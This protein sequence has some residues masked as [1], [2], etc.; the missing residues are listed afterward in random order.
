MNWRL[1]ATLGGLLPSRSS[2]H[3]FPENFETDKVEPGPRIGEWMWVKVHVCSG[4]Q[5]VPETG[6]LI[7]T[8]YLSRIV[9]IMGLEACS[10]P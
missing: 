2:K 8:R 4:R 9:A 7:D 1:G 10:E 5:G 3:P 6:L